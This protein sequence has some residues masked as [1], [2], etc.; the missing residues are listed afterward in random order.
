MRRI[1]RSTI[2]FDPRLK[3]GYV[4]YIIVTDREKGRVFRVIE[5]VI[6]V[7]LDYSSWLRNVRYKELSTQKSR[8]QLPFLRL[9]ANYQ[10][11]NEDDTV[12]L[13]Y[14]NDSADDLLRNALYILPLYDQI[15]SQ[16][17]SSSFSSGEERRGF[18]QGISRLL[19]EKSVGMRGKIGERR[20]LAKRYIS[21]LYNFH[22]D[23][24]NG[25]TVDEEDDADRNV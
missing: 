15:I 6:K 24:S 9:Y 22:N 11:A 23:V 25:K 2:K 4:D 19:F 7:S 17:Q 14:P 16:S 10:R 18:L 8:H 1:I 12:K 21:W 5:Y 3:S 20:S 13:F